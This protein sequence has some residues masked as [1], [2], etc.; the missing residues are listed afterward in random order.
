MKPVRFAVPLGASLAV[1]VVAASSRRSRRR[2]CCSRCRATRWSSSRSTSSRPVSD[3]IAAISQEAR[4]RPDA[5][6]RSPIRSATAEGSGHQAGR[7]PE[8]R[9]GDRLRQRR[10]WTSDEPPLLIL[11]PVTDY[12][13]FLKNFADA[14]TEDEISI[15]KI[16]DERTTSFVDAS[17]AST[18]DRCRRSAS[19]SRRSRTALSR[20]G[21]AAK[22]IDAKDI[23][24]YVNMKRRDAHPAGAEEEPREDPRRIREGVAPGRA[25][26]APPRRT[27]GGPPKRRRRRGCRRPPRPIRRRKMLPLVSA[28]STACSTSP[29]R[30]SPTPTPPP[31]AE[32]SPTPASARPA[33]V[34]FT[35]DSPSGKARRAAQEHRRVAAQGPAGR[36]VLV[37]GGTVGQQRGAG[38]KLV[39]EFLAPIE[40]EFAAARRRGQG[41]AGL[42]RPPHDSTSSTCTGRAS[43]GRARRA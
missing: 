31:T 20:R 39:N 25:A 27:G 18:R 35:P 23:V 5:A 4:P 12:K 37:F 3:K 19:S 16:K 6:R 41:D 32:R 15:V 22:E 11:V 30:S 33:L 26:A 24:A 34:E 28:S 14:K 7:R 21:L 1:V 8:R 42:P 17:A 40:K 2:R 43:A 38:R 36:Q 29:S 9:R 13:A 10:R